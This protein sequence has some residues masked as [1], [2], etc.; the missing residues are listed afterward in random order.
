MPHADRSAAESS[1]KVR[2]PV[3][4]GKMCFCDCLLIP[5]KRFAVIMRVG[6][7]VTRAGQSQ[8][9]TGYYIGLSETYIPSDTVWVCCR[10]HGKCGNS[11]DGRY[12]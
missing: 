6:N 5:I 4:N 8:E 1:P 10:Y 9:S 3:N 2:E 12:F 7:P 11:P